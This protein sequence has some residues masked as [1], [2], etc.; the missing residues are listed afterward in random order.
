MIMVGCMLVVG[1][2]VHLG[3]AV[4]IYRAKIAETPEQDLQMINEVM[5]WHLQPQKMIEID[6]IRKNREGSDS[7]IC[8]DNETQLEASTPYYV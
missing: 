2:F 8:D 3:R 7:G 5:R 4:C 1:G 6:N